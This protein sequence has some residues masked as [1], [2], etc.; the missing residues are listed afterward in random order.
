MTENKP[1]KTYRA[2]V[3]SLSYWEKEL[4]SGKAKTF[5][6][7]RSYKDKAEKWQHTQTLTVQ[8]LPKLKV[9]IEE[10]YKEQILNETENE[11]S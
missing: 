8:D 9:L 1:I 3:L 4:E 6:F 10:A 5:S 2:G 11:M 7:Q